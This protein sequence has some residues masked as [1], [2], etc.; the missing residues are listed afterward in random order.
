[1]LSSP[2]LAL[3][4]G[5]APPIAA[6]ATRRVR[7]EPNILASVTRLE[8]RGKSRILALDGHPGMRKSSPYIRIGIYLGLHGMLLGIIRRTSSNG[9]AMLGGIYMANLTASRV[10]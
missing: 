5:T 2:L 9:I 7:T 6:T 1:M 10:M 4:L 8:S 3:P